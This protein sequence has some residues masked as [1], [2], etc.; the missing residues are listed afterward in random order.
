VFLSI[1]K[2]FGGKEIIWESEFG[3]SMGDVIGV[4]SSATKNKTFTSENICS[5]A[6]KGRFHIEYLA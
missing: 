6:S 2:K 5:S 3:A 4:L 1:L